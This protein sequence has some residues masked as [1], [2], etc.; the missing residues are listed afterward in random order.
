[1]HRLMG[2]LLVVVSAVAFGLMPLFAH[3]ALDSGTSVPMLMFLRFALAAPLMML[4]MVS[5][6]RGAP[7]W[8]RGPV[9]IG[10]ALMGAI[11]YVGESLCYFTAL[12]YAPAGLVALLLY[13][14]PVIV[15]VLARVIFGERLTPLRMLALAVALAGTALT[16]GPIPARRD[17][18]LTGIVLSL[19]TAVIYA[20]YILAGTRLTRGVGPLPAATVVVTA[21]AIVYGVMVLIERP[22]LPP[23]S[24]AWLGAMSLALVSTVIGITAFLAGLQRIGPVQAATLS[25]IE[26]LVSVAVGAAFL[27]EHV[28][29]IQGLGGALILTAA[30]MTARAGRQRRRSADGASAPDDRQIT[31]GATR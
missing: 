9:L 1:M 2:A 4:V 11:G 3:W 14:Y 5:R 20:G 29:P 8:P 24:R 18:S 22:T 10:L 13:V 21:A 7:G 16:I 25:T 15:T 28:W 17:G 26:P 27:R 12:N 31:P 19:S 6:R 30:V 23:T